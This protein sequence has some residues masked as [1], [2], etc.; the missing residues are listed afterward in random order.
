MAVVTLTDAEVALHGLAGT[1]SL[2]HGRALA[3]SG[4]VSSVVAD[5]SGG[6]VTAMKPAHA[7]SSA[8][9]AEPLLGAPAEE[10]FR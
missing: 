2:L 7:A 8:A 10:A 5:P 6:R 4:R 9:P 3:R 1:A